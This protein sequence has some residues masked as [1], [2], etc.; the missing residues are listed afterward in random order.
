MQF[1][2]DPLNIRAQDA[3][4]RSHELVRQ[5]DKLR[6]LSTALL[7]E[8][9]LRVEMKAAA[10]S[11]SEILNWAVHAARRITNANMANLQILDPGSRTLRIAAQHGFS[12]KFLDYFDS[13][14]D[15]EAACGMALE[16]GRRVI[17]K[18]VTES[19]VF[20]GTAILEIL[21][22]AGVRAVQSTPLVGRSGSIIGMLS[23]HWSWP[24]LP[25]AQDLRHLDLLARTV[26]NC[27]ESYGYNPDGV[28][29]RPS[30]QGHRGAL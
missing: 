9:V 1:T 18:D 24:C 2:A 12:Q 5:A 23:T 26:A 21:L 15:G 20:R 28:M 3:I 25:S 27:L 10:P 14:P 17:V 22:D 4:R 19:P 13:V 6:V 29:H 8:F 11:V 30:A 7:N 16:T